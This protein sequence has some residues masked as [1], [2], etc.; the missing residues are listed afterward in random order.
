MENN[1]I[2]ILGIHV[3]HRMKEVGQIQ[4]IFSKY[5]CSIKTRLG[6]HE[7]NDNV[8]SPAGIILLEL[9]GNTS[10]MDNMEN[11]L[12]QVQGIDVQKMSFKN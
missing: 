1:E 10:D 7:V 11:E 6:L 9:V 8:C 2:R 12:K 3:S 5:G 4:P